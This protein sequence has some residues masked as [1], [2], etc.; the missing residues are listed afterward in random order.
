MLALKP[1]A[2]K[3]TDCIRFFFFFFL[4]MSYFVDRLSCYSPGPVLGKTTVTPAYNN[5]DFR[6][7]ANY[8]L[9]LYLNCFSSGYRKNLSSRR[10][11]LLHSTCIQ[12]QIS[13]NSL[14][15]LST[16]KFFFISLFFLFFCCC[17]CVKR[18]PRQNSSIINV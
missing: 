6:I 12:C 2:T 8:V 3:L 1:P 16:W 5:I 17:C 11:D 15:K 4:S 13:T 14:K 18:V 7:Q 10:R 9:K